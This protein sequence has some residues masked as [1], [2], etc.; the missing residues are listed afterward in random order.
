LGIGRTCLEDYL[1][2]GYIPRGGSTTESGTCINPVA[3]TLNFM[4]S[5]YAIARAAERLNKMEDAE[6]LML[7]SL[8]YSLIF[9]GENGFMQSKS[10][11]TGKW[12]TAFDQFAW[13]GDYTEGGPWQFRFYVP[14]DPKGLAKLYAESAGLNMCDKLSDIQ[15]M[16]G[17]YHLGDY[18]MEIHEEL[19]LPEN[20]W[21]Q[22]AHN[23]Q[24]THHI[25]YMFSGMDDAGVRG[26]CASKGQYW[27]R[28]AQLELYNLRPAMYAGDEDNGEM[29]AWYILSTLGLF[30]LAPGTTEI[31]FGVPLFSKAT[32]VTDASKG[33]LLSIISNNNSPENVY[34]QSVS[35]NGQDYSG[36][37][38]IDYNDLVSGGELV[39]EMGNSPYVSAL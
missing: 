6:I 25:L 8:N 33:T 26:T 31:M 2:L 39:F 28:K 23:N 22:Y 4:Q 9:N 36:R 34:I 29:S 16:P 5:D 30:S 20:C 32:V 15:T 17:V 37:N 13:G 24:P 38:G 35:W 11:E 18:P 1:A 7:R 27:L 3:Q 12:T 14:H 19:E 10:K 21:G